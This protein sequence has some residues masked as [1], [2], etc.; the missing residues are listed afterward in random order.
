MVKKRPKAK[1]PIIAGV[2]DH[3]GWAILVSVT[4]KD[5]APEVIDRRRVELLD[6]GL[7]PLP[8]EHDTVGLSALAAEKL[9]QE[10]RDSAQHCAERAL[11]KLRSSLEPA[12]DLVAIALRTSPLPQLP[13]TVAEV[14][15]SRHV[16]LRADGM[17]YLAALRT[18]ATSLGI[19]VIDFPRGEE[20]A[21]AAE[22]TT[23]TPEQ[24]DRFLTGLRQT[25]GAPWQ[26]DH[27]T[28]TARALAAL[29]RYAT[30][31]LD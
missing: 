10:V 23:S 8:Y 20:R 12:G 27:Q 24:L 11:S 4:V 22:A 18:A 5:G 2:A 13:H 29:R 3:A 28:A 16:T 14:H 7:P 19:A 30:F 26:Q 21:R 17:L 1:T 9:I 25:L 6:P 15:A 31:R